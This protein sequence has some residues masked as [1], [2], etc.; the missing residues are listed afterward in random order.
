MGIVTLFGSYRKKHEDLKNSSFKIP[1]AVA[2]CGIL[3]ALTIFTYIGNM[4]A[5]GNIPISQ[6]PLGGPG[7]LYSFLKN[8]IISLKRINFCRISHSSNI[9]AIFKFLGSDFFYHDD[10]FR[11]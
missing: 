2:F 4:S 5:S 7:F 6:I 1:Y 3:A 10:F 8:N 11:A 9:Y